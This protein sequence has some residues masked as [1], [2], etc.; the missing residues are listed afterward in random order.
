MPARRCSEAYRTGVNNMLR[1]E[2][3]LIAPEGPPTTL[4][5][6]RPPRSDSR[7]DVTTDCPVRFCFC[8]LPPRLRRPSTGSGVCKVPALTAVATQ[9]GSCSLLRLRSCIGLLGNQ[10]RV[11]DPCLIPPCGI[12]RVRNGERP[13][14]T[15]WLAPHL[16]ASQSD[17]CSLPLLQSQTKV[18][19]TR[20]AVQC[21]SSGRHGNGGQSPTS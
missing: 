19:Q 20:P 10:V 1:S 7:P 3:S 4:Q 2:G 11:S 8:Q 9:A 16:V 5:V 13:G 17:S 18:A 6:A 21:T 14:E 15:R 12:T